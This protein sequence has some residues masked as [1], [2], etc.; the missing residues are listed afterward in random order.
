MHD[1]KEFFFNYFLSQTTQLVVTLLANSLS[2]IFL[3]LF[4]VIDIFL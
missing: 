4:P 2:F 1:I 3:C